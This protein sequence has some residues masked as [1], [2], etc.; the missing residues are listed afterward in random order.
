MILH[1]FHDVKFN[2]LATQTSIFLQKRKTSFCQ[3][4]PRF[5]VSSYP[6]FYSPRSQEETN[7]FQV[8]HEDSLWSHYEAIVYVLLSFVDR[9]TLTE[10]ALTLLQ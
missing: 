6:N 7:D 1:S 4:E 2:T 3:R 5:L 8:I 10:T 9:Y